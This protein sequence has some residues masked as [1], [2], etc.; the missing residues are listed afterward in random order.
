MTREDGLNRTNNLPRGW[1]LRRWFGNDQMFEL[2]RY[3]WLMK[4]RIYT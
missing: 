4:K 1:A 3:S 2:V